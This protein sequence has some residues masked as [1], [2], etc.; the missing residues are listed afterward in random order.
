MVAALRMHILW[1]GVIKVKSKV[2]KGSWISEQQRPGL[3]PESRSGPGWWTD[4]CVCAP[5]QASL[6]QCVRLFWRQRTRQCRRWLSKCWNVSLIF[7]LQWL[8]LTESAAWW[9]VLHYRPHVWATGSGSDSPVRDRTRWNDEN[10]LRRV[11][12]RK[13]QSV[14][15]FSV[16]LLCVFRVTPQSACRR[17][18]GDSGV[19][20]QDSVMTGS[21][22]IVRKS[23]RS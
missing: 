18:E 10:L 1:S 19:Q 6:A 15:H 14:Q 7:L 23:I 5:V 21:F 13:Q 2:D 17:Q 11:S 22:S 3:D 16:W 8:D 9:N 20:S 4:K 12:R